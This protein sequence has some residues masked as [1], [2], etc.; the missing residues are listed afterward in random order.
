[1]TVAAAVLAAALALPAAG[2][3]APAPTPA[4]EAP[5]PHGEGAGPGEAAPADPCHHAGG[6]DVLGH[7]ANS[8]CLEMPLVPFRV[9]TLPPG[10][11]KVSV[12][13]LISAGV[14]VLLCALARRG[15]GLVPRGF[16]NFLEALVV[17]V[18]DEIAVKNLG[19]HHGRRFT[20]YL[21]TVFF[22]ILTCN[23]VGLVP[24]GVT[25][26]GNINVTATLALCTL[27][28]MQLSGIR[29]HGLVGHVKNL[30]PHGIPK[31]LLVVMIPVEVMGVLAKP[32]ALSVRLFANM[33]AGHVVILSLLGLIFTFGTAWVSPVSIGFSLFIFLL[34]LLV[35]F[36]Q[37]Y[38]FTMLT[39]LFIGMSI[40]AH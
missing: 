32:F 9:F 25:V 1:M 20:P 31:W 36:L 2:E 12:W 14:L 33:T 17:F 34:E 19:E 24:G 22:F 40:H 30:V 11:T 8:R 23:V 39:A 7:L 27:F 16:Y 21:L 37:A 13:I 35:A 26:T 3:E 4:V 29:E 38:I 5:V 18:R 15:M 28:L 10:L 6:F